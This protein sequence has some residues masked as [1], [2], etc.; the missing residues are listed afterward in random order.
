MK[1]KDGYIS[2][3]TP[4]GDM[5][6]YFTHPDKIKLP[7]LIVF[8]EAFG[9]NAH[10]KDVCRRFAQEG[11]FVVAPELYHRQGHHLEFSYSDL[12]Q[13]MSYLKE[14]SQESLKMDTQVVL[15]M[16]HEIPTVDAAKIATI[17]FC[18]G[19]YTSILAAASFKLSGC[20]AFYGAGMLTEREG[21]KLKPFKEQLKNISSPLL[22]FFGQKDSSIPLSEVHEIQALLEKEE[23][24]FRSVVFENSHHGFFCD[25]R[26]SYNKVAADDAWEMSLEFLKE[27]FGSQT[28]SL[29]EGSVSPASSGVAEF[30][31]SA[32]SLD[33][34]L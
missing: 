11:Y 24:A 23:K 3:Q 19:G 5:E 4:D 16:L 26:K 10:I 20:I 30:K 34:S 21:L 9:V 15:D 25:Q 32:G 7:A 1:L 12:S 31:S 8:Q 18:V 6:V 28:Y 2:L 22:L 14:L 27:I 17:G 33:I 13:A 29:N